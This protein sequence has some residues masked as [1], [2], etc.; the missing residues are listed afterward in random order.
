[1][2]QSTRSQNSHPPANLVGRA[3]CPCMCEAA[4]TNPLGRCSNQNR[5]AV[6]VARELAARRHTRLPATCIGQLPVP[7]EDNQRT[8]T[9]M[10][11][12]SDWKRWGARSSLRNGGYDPDRRNNGIGDFSTGECNTCIR[13][14]NR[15][16]LW[17]MPR[18]RCRR[19]QAYARGGSLQGERKQVVIR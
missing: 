14:A 7:V 19:W 12:E 13:C 8:E 1:M 4:Q 17:T 9:E 15:E 10:R 2:A 16:G 6:G 18:K 5:L 11:Y 3:R